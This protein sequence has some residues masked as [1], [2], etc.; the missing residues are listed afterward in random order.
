MP[1][2]DW[3]VWQ[4]DRFTVGWI[5]WLLF[6]IVWESWALANGYRGTLTAHLRPVFLSWPLSWWLAFGAWLWI[7]VHLLAPAAERALLDLMRGN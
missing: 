6:F 1:L 3:S 4:L 7:G 2:A 5:V